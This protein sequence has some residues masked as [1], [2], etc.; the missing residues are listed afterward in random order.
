[1]A[2]VFPSSGEVL[3][4][5]LFWAPEDEDELNGEA[6][7]EGVKGVDMFACFQAANA[8]IQRF[9]HVGREKPPPL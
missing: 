4:P 2:V 8:I 3:L 5:F 1:V 6:K 9:S 7:R